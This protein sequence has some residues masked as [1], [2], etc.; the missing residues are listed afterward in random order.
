MDVIERL[1]KQGKDLGYEG[2]TLQT[3][4]K[5]QQIE[6]RDE[7]KA[8]REAEHERREAERESREAENAKREAE[9]KLEREKLEVKCEIEKEVREA[10]REAR[11]AETAKREAEAKF[12]RDKSE[13]EE[14][15]KHEELEIME[16]IVREKHD[17]E[18]EK[19][20]ATEKQRKEEREAAERQSKEER[21][22]AERHDQLLCNMEKA[23]LALEQDRINSQQFQQQRDY[24]FKCQLQDRQHEDELERLEAQ[25]AL[26][27]PRETIKAKAPKIPAFNEGKDEM[28]FYLLRF[29]RYATAQKWEPDTWAT[30]LSALLQGKAL[31]VYALMPK[32]DALN[33]DKLK[34]ALLKR[35]ELTE[36]GF[37]RKY[38]K[39]RPENGE[40]FQQFT[41]RMKS[42]F[43][44]W[45]DM[46]SIE[47]SYKG[48]QDLILRE[49][50]TFICNRELFLRERE[51]KS[52]EQASKLADQ[53]KEA[54]YVDIVSLTYK[55]NERSR[56]RSNSESRSRSPIRRGPNQGNQGY[57]RVRCYNCGG[58]HVRRFCPQLKQG[59]MKAGAVDYRRSRSPTRKVTFQTQEPEVP[60]EETAK[61]G[62]QNTE[63]K[64]CGACLILTD[65]VNYSQATTNEREMV[66]T[67]VGSPI[68]VSSV[69]SL[70]E[71]S[72]VQGFVGEKPVEVLRD[73][74]CS[75]VIVSKDLVPESAYTGRSQTMV[76]VDYSSRVVPEVK[77][78]IDTPYYKGEVLALCVEKPL[79]GLIIG[80]IPG[81]RER[82]NP[83]INWVPALA[84][85]TRAQ[86]KREGVTSKLKT[87]NIIDRTITPA[88]VSKAQ[89]DDVSLTTTRSRCEANETIGKAT[90]L[91]KNDLLYRKFSSPN[92]EHGRTFTQ[93]IVP[94]QYR[95]LVMKLA[96]ESVMAGHLA[97][98]RTMQKVLSEFYWPG[99]NSDIKRF[100]QSCDI[101]QRTIPKGKI[102]K[103]PLGKMP[104]IDV[105]FRR[106]ATD[107]IGPLKPVTYNKNRYILT[108]VDYATRY[109]EAVPLASIDTETVAEA[110]VSIFSRV[111]NPHEILTDMGTQY[112]SAVMKEVS[113]L[114][115]FKQLVTTPYH[116]ICNGLVERFNQT[117]K[118][119]LMRMCAERPKDW[120]KYIDPL[121]FAYRE[122]PQESLGFSPFE[123]LY[124]WPV[125]GPM[126]IL[127]QLWSKEIEDPEVRSTYQYVIELRDR[128]ESTLEIAQDNLSK[129]SR[130][131]KR[132]Y[133]QK[134]GKRQLKVGGKAL[135]LL[136]TDKNKLL[137]GWKGPYEVVE[138]LSPLDYR[139]RISGKEKS[140]HINMLKQYVERE[141]DQE[142]QSNDES[143]VCAVSLVDLTA[144]E[145][146]DECSD[147]LIETP[148]VCESGEGTQVNI[149]PALSQEEQHQVRSLVQEFSG[150]FSEK[151]GRTTL[152]EH[153]IKLTT[154][155]PVRVKQYPLPYSMMQAVNDEV[156]SMIELGVIERSESPYC[157]PVIIVK[158]KDNTNRFCIDFRVL[159]KITVFDAE[160]M[161]SME[162]IFAKLAGYKF[163]SKLDLSKGYWQIALSDRSKPYTAFQTPLGLFQ[164]TVLPFGLV[165]AQ[166]SC[167]RLMR[168][169]LQN[170]SN[171][172][173]FVD[174]II[175]FTLTWQQHIDTLRALLQRLRE[176]NLTVKPVKCFIGFASIECLGH[177]VSEGTLQPCQDKINSILHA[178]RPTTKK[179]VRSFLGLVG[180][181]R[182]FIKNFSELAAPLTELTKKGQ[183]N[184]DIKRGESQEQAFNQLRQ[185]LVSKPILKMV[186]I[187]K[188]FTL[189]VDASDL[190]IGAI[191]LQ[192]E[193]GKKVPVAYASRK[194][195]QSERS[196]AVIEK[197][198]L[199]LVW[200][201]QKFSRYL[202]G[203]PFTVETDHCPLKYLNEAKLKNARLMRW[204]LILQPYR[205]HINA[206]KGSENAGADYLSRV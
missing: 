17:I 11:E 142:M 7:R 92:V 111:G 200:A 43:T 69:S 38:K 34:V 177:M 133:D 158:K 50:L 123:L 35:Y 122:A 54:R 21:E 31:D 147:G 127:K 148:S 93:L 150:T 81:A 152:M 80:N 178:E 99:I 170:L 146:E 55:N 113:R 10:A 73:T 101:C 189:Q 197:E 192:E 45:I 97:I 165:T 108:L 153:D 128:L 12:E 105:P 32:E 109:P 141:D 39:C 169:L 67:S 110:L 15:F 2:E 64:V 95:T 131:Y 163:I 48:L 30:G 175:I 70:S 195:K 104:R 144:E 83:D 140:F 90:F 4:V 59:I 117:I 114:L 46:A 23:K 18:R 44:R 126:Q 112:T 29:E 19:I 174:D 202:Y 157:S 149:N 172:D 40:T 24:E 51:P 116:P 20:E 188:P 14:L 124:G 96:Q 181:Y 56:S 62:N 134:A 145:M 86:A 6:L 74:G 194:L 171:V 57:P 138:K 118:K 82:N 201:V 84:V 159:N 89:K 66:K 72:T 33:Y 106:V 36:E 37:K 68:K 190:G 183:R 135:V 137:M 203:T 42:Y 75:G 1:T 191:V 28:D 103:A 151:P 88:Q 206:I 120:D 187:S 161:P 52:L 85:Q 164:F 5:E 119:M 78:S 3:F 16:R 91:K 162:Q 132:H 143:Q 87:P 22:A 139:I 53:Y 180:F 58:P 25:K 185:A 49:Q 102:V 63:P 71:M 130:K 136:P 8:M 154:D 47:K 129:M 204:A 198:C 76:M 167:S 94:Q 121:L 115:S 156:R 125:R 27:Q 77:V 98:K 166:A 61:D 13:A 79:V 160:P 205:I 9:A 176:A 184:Q 182:Q 100:C 186:E 193:N 179:Q 196:Y 107:L 199:A 173:N 26:T 41:T 168:K 65:A 155:T 60:K